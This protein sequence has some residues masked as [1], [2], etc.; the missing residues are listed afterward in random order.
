MPLPSGITSVDTLQVRP[1]P[2]AFVSGQMLLD[3]YVPSTED[4]F[5]PSD[6]VNVSAAVSEP[7][8]EG[9]SDSPA[10]TGLM[11][12]SILLMLLYMSKFL[13]LIPYFSA[14]MFRWKVLAELERN[15]RLA[16]ERDSLV[17]PAFIIFCT[18][19]S[20]FSVLVLPPAEALSPELKTLSVFGLVAAVLLIRKLLY[21][22]VP[23]GKMKINRDSLATANGA[24]RDFFIMLTLILTIILF[25]ATFLQRWEMLLGDIVLYVIAAF[26][27]FFI[28]RKMQILSADAGLLRAI[29]YLCSMEIP[30]AAMLVVSMLIL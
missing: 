6:S 15:M 12:V 9:W 13:R 18:I 8:R 22:V 7:W 20:R 16:R 29:L 17:F 11:L 23:S 10:N 25:A 30:P 21:I 28:L 14:G 1:G 24:G 5:R 19:L 26:W 3:E 4:I 27:A 2:E